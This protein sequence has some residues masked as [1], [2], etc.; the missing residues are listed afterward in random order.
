M[1]WE[2]FIKR[3]KKKVN[4]LFFLEQSGLIIDERHEKVLTGSPHFPFSFSKLLGYYW[5]FAPLC[6][7]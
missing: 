1:E 5:S 6:K 2:L 4:S 3:K 7:F